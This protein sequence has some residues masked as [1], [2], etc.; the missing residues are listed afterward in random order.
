MVSLATE[1]LRVIIAAFT[2]RP[3]AAAPH[4]PPVSFNPTVYN[5]GRICLDILQK[6]WSPIYDV[7]AVLTSIRSLLTDPN[8]DSPANPEAARL[9]TENRRTY[10]DRVKKCVEGSL[11]V[12]GVTTEELEEA[13]REG[14][15]AAEREAGVGAAAAAGGKGGQGAGGAM[16]DGDSDSSSSSG[17]DSSD[18]DDSDSD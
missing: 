18:S 7:A 9:Y 1:R 5:D 2:W 17:S 3:C 11:V 14:E 6:N 16:G 13:E 8:P 15:M 10:L 12:A 4:P